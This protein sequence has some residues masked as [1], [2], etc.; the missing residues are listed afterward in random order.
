M[1]HRDVSRSSTPSLKARCWGRGKMYL[2]LS[3]L[4]VVMQGLSWPTS[5]Q[6][7]GDHV[8]PFFPLIGKELKKN[9]ST[10]GCCTWL[11][12]Q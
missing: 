4:S 10:H 1:G 2:V 11:T 7:D 8:Y 9:G 6:Q 5:E 3:F 12:D